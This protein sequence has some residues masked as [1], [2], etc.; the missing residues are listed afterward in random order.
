MAL[1]K[2]KIDLCIK[3]LFFDISHVRDSLGEKEKVSGGCSVV[4]IFQ[5][6]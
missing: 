3:I 6:L 4:G 5:K 1:M 2:L